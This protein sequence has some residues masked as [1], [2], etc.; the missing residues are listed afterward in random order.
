MVHIVWPSQDADGTFHVA[1]SRSADGGQTWSSPARVDKTPTGSAA[2]PAVAA[3]RTGT[4]AV[5]Y[6]DFRARKVPLTSVGRLLGDYTGLVSTGDFFT[7]VY[8]V[9]TG[10]AA[11][12]VDLHSAIFSR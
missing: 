8:G 11:N 3:S 5:T 1:Y 12:P 7:A 2:V 10:D 4:V 6:Y 9:T